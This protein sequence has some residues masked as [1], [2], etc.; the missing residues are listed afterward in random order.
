MA[1]I[2][3]IRGKDMSLGAYEQQVKELKESRGD[4]NVLD[5]LQDLRTF[6]GTK[7]ADSLKLTERYIYKERFVK[8][9]EDIPEEV[10]ILNFVINEKLLLAKELGVLNKIVFG[11]TS[12]KLKLD[13]F[14]LARAGEKIEQSVFDENQEIVNK[15]KKDKSKEE[16][17]EAAE[18]ER[19][20]KERIAL[21]AKL[22]AR[23]ESQYDIGNR[24][25]N[26]ELIDPEETP[27]NVLIRAV[28]KGKILS[29][30]TDKLKAEYKE[31]CDMFGITPYLWDN[32]AK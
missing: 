2:F 20:E 27:K 24:E 25:S 15:K 4:D 3:L 8:V 18:K 16:A 10:F 5:Y 31:I 29:V 12:D 13:D 32:Y 1:V 26:V 6:V 11:K 21:I 14:L 28:K 22:R 19:S 17:K 23:L 30:D 9:G 7:Y